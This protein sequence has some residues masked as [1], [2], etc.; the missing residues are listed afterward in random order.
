[1]PYIPV[2]PAQKEEMLSFLGIP[3]IEELFREI[4]EQFRFPSLNLEEGQSEAETL[5]ELS[6]MA[7]KNADADG[8]LWFLGG[9][10]YNHFV[11]AAV[12]SLASRGEYLTAYTPYQSEVS[13]GTLQTIFEYQSMIG[14]LTGMEV[15]NAGHYDGASALAEGALMALRMDASKR[16]VLIPAALHPE[17]RAVL[18]S[19][20]A[21]HDCVLETYSGSPAA[22]AEKGGEDLA[23]LIALYPDF[24]GTIPDLAGAAEA[25]HHKG[26]LFIIHADP[27]MLGLLKSPG[28]WGADLVSAEGQSLGNDLNYGGPF[29]GIM[30]ASAALMRRLPGR[31][32]GE[33]EDLDKRR[34]F[35]LTLTAREQHIRR[36]KAVSNICSNQ[37]L[38]A[39]RACIYLALMGKNGLRELARLCWH[40]S[41]YGARQ[42]AAI[43][44]CRVESGVFFKEFTVTLP[45]DAEELAEKLGAKKIIPGLPLSRYYPGR[46]NELLVCITEM[47]SKKDIDTL[48]GAIREAYL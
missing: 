31:I 35:V 1:V 33:T 9:G 44:G 25:V 22:A 41:H 11:P 20:L 46:R 8:W 17:Y 36:E 28:A 10:A 43:P 47:N 29:L 19:Y 3:S 16:R 40:R 6:A 24:F 15:V 42:I 32:V 12:A 48:A 5:R 30:A 7:E 39:L 21:P 34:G 14:A 45:G 26:G 37:G 2:T 18:E 23:A 13:Q 27:I 4:P 38:A